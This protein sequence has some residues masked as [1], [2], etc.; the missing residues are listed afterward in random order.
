MNS[1]IQGFAQDVYREF[2]KT[3]QNLNQSR[4]YFLGKRNLDWKNKFII[5]FIRAKPYCR[6]VVIPVSIIGF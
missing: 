2:V 1:Y 3:V 4:F 6:Y 5:K